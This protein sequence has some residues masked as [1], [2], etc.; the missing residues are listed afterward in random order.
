MASIN[1]RSDY[2]VSNA[3]VFLK[4]VWLGPGGGSLVELS[5]N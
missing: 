3:L 2:V 1:I 4:M 5:A